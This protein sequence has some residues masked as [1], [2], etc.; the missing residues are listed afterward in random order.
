MTKFGSESDRNLFIFRCLS[1][2][3]I[4]SFHDQ[5]YISY[6]R[7]LT[8]RG[9][10]LMREEAMETW[11]EENRKFDQSQTWLINSLLP[12]IHQRS[13]LI[14]RYYFHGPF[15]DVAERL[16]GQNL[17]GVTS[18]LS[19]KLRGNTKIAPWHQDNGY[20]ELDPYTA[21]TCITA[22]DDTDVESGC[23]WIIPGGHR[24]GQIDVTDQ[25]TV[26]SKAAMVEVSI[27]VD[28]TSAI[29]IPMKAGESLIFHGWMPHKSLGNRSD[30][31][32][33][34][35]FL[36]YADADA[37]EVYNNR[38]PRLG[39]LIRGKTRFPEVEAFETDLD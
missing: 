23:L 7:L 5:G 13:N 9:L 31:D 20:G 34:L 12:N 4:D 36:R 18:Q 32:R 25:L 29:P 10:A 33:R 19:F 30:R 21:I 37:V 22:L 27:E 2:E 38:K 6:G 15:V 35:L 8:D 17:K 39:R 24:L 28:E 16:V 26:E 1:D 3:Q 14:R 11:N